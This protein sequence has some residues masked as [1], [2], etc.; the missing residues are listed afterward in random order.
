MRRCIEKNSAALSQ[1]ADKPRDGFHGNEGGSLAGLAAAGTMVGDIP[2]RRRLTE[3]Y[4]IAIHTC[5]LLARPF[6]LPRLVVVS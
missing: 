2:R 5:N 3:L 6:L 4:A 1:P